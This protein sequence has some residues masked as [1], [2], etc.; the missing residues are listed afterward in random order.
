M[1]QVKLRPVRRDYLVIEEVQPVEPGFAR[2]HA[3]GQVVDV[4]GLVL[5]QADPAHLGRSPRLPAAPC[6]AAISRDF[7]VD[8]RRPTPYARR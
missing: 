7:T 1:K 8:S 3:S 4:G 5:R 6:R 2:Q